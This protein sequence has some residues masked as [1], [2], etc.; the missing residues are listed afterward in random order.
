MSLDPAFIELNQASTDRMR[1][2]VER[3]SDAQLQH[4]VGG[5][6]TVSIALAH[7]AFWER[8]ALQALD[9]TERD[10]A[11]NWPALD[12]FV[13]DLSLPLWA[14]I[15]PR[16]AATIALDSAAALDARL[17]AFPP[18]LLEQL[19][20]ISP[21]LITRAFHRN[22]HLDEIDEALGQAQP[23]AAPVTAVDRGF[24]ALNRAASQRLRAFAERLSDDELRRP[25]GQ[26][27]TV[28]ILLAHLAF[29]D[30]RALWVLDATQRARRAVNPDYGVF[31]NDISLPF[32]AAVPAR[33]AANLAIE[34][35]EAADAR[36]EAYPA[37]LL[38]LIH[39]DYPR[40][41]FRARHRNEH[42]DEAE[43]ALKG[44]DEG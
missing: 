35:A 38:A 5:H 16:A 28:A 37:D 14:T 24:V 7:I 18:A 39:A 27:W 40:Y 6:W 26:H 20:A 19:Y 9:L 33:Q 12:I 29:T 17:A 43:A 2:L 15:P 34:T 1:A 36:L 32:W 22:E 42:L 30:G 8:R 10:G 31:V 11:V 44:K 23:A 3:L 25:V 13:N 4:P 21:R 41:I